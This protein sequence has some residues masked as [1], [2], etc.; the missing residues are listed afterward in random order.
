MSHSESHVANQIQRT[1]K[2]W[3]LD[4][5]MG[6]WC[7][8]PGRPNVSGFQADRAYRAS[9]LHARSGKSIHLRFKNSISELHRQRGRVADAPE[10][11]VQHRRLVSQNGGHKRKPSQFFSSLSSTQ[12][13]K[14]GF[15]LQGWVP[16]TGCSPLMWLQILNC[17]FRPLRSADPC[18]TSQQGCIL[19]SAHE[20]THHAKVSQS[21]SK[22]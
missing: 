5:A 13:A 7:A 18:K 16:E 4:P 9:P 1:R 6:P 22:L 10:S 12:L 14:R 21:K 15:Q 8:Q 11:V 19:A 20:Q 3:H 2:V 17:I